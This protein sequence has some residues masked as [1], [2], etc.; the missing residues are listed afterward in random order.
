M[1]RTVNVAVGAVVSLSN[2]LRLTHILSLLLLADRLQ[3]LPCFLLQVGATLGWEHLLFIGTRPLHLLVYLHR[4]DGRSASP[5]LMCMLDRNI[6]DLSTLELL[7][8]NILD[9]SASSSDSSRSSSSSN[10]SPRYRH[11]DHDAAF[12]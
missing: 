4:K 9:S 3:G 1:P 8:R 7:D 6:L 5:L 2:R 12:V 11:K 10:S